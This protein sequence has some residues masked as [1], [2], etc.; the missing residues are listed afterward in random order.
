LFNQC[1]FSDQSK[2]MIHVFFGEREVAK[3]PGIGKDV[4]QIEIKKA[5]VVGAGTMGGGI[6]MNYANAG[7]PVIIKETTQEP[8]DRGVATIRK[9]YQNSVNKGRFPQE[10]MDKR[11]A[12]ITPQLTYDGFEDADII[13]EAVFEGMALKKEVFGELDKIAKPGAIL[14]S[15]TST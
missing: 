13:T 2:A 5:A 12:L 1:L 14:A 9:N 6:A 7:I 15:N 4:W 8:L 11:L 3:I 10:V